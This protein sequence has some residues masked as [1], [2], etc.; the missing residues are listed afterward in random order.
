MTT[1]IELFF[2]GLICVTPT[3]VLF[4]DLILNICNEIQFKYIFLKRKILI[5]IQINNIS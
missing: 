1:S 5:L 3:E 4:L 2:L